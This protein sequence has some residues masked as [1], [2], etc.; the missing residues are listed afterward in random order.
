M[1]LDLFDDVFLLDL[2][3]KPAESVFKSFAL[4]KPYFSQTEYTSRLDQNFRAARR[5]A[6][7]QGAFESP[8][9]IPALRTEGTDII[10]G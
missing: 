1:S 8:Q 6:L 5:R 7:P 2:P 3:L 10:G 9:K 4:L